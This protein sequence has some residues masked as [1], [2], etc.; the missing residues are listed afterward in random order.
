MPVLG[1]AS[2]H[3]YHKGTVNRRALVL[4]SYPQRAPSGNVR[5]GSKAERLACTAIV[6]F[7][8]KLK[9][10]MFHSGLLRVIPS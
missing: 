7:S 6:G 10:K 2:W 9:S 8:H 5:F 1:H 3:L 4:R